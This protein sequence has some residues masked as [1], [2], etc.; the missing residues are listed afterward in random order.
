[1][2]YDHGTQPTAMSQAYTPQE[3]GGGVAPKRED[4]PGDRRVD[5]L[6]RMGVRAGW[7]EHVRQRLVLEAR[8]DDPETMYKFRMEQRVAPGRCWSHD[9]GVEGMRSDAGKMGHRASLLRRG[10][11]LA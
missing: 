3:A 8:G 1:M 5:R 6:R 11:S 10:R 9:R 2:K 4:L 7:Q